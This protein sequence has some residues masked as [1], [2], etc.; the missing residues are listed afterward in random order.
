V[1]GYIARRILTG[2]LMIFVLTVITYLVFATVPADPGMY[3]TGL[4]TTPAELKAADHALGVDHPTYIQYLHFARGLL[5]GDFGNSYATGAPVSGIIRAALPVTAAIVIGG[6]VL[7][8]VMALLI[9]VGSAMRPH[10][11]FDR[12]LNALIMCGVALHPLVVGLVL[13]SVF[14]YT[15]PLAPTS[16]YCPLTG[17]GSCGAHAWA[18]HLALPW[19]TFMLF[20]LP[21]YAR[22]IRTQVLGLLTQPHVVAARAKGASETRV[23]RVHVLPLLIPTLA[24]M[25]AIDVS[26]SLMAAIY[27]EAAFALPGIGTQALQA[28]VGFLGLDLPVI[29]GVVT[30]VATAVIISNVVA[31]II[32]AK[33]DPRIVVARRTFS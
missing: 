33:A 13:Q 15:I 10:T 19:I 1:A 17:S 4:R 18:A 21:L 22:V 3:L 7:L 20:L 28:Q 29:V 12:T 24:T 14:V 26:T 32:A 30:V 5:H 27:I 2:L 23:L 31:D 8:V 9:G 11:L 25:L 6:A 16:G